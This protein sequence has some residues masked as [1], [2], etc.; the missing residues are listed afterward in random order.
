MY[1]VIFVLVPLLFFTGQAEARHRHYYHNRYQLLQSMASIPSD[2]RIV[3]DRPS[4][5]PSA[6]C[7]CEASLYKF[8][9][10]IPALNLASNW[11][12]SRALHLLQA[13]RRYDQDTS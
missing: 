6:F 12:G 11:R 5:C 4:G 1:R 8:G 9:C 10:I 2:E 7:G 13:W 3:N